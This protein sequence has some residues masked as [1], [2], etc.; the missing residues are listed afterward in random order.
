MAIL[1]KPVLTFSATLA[2]IGLVRRYGAIATK[3]GKQV[4]TSSLSDKIEKREKIGVNAA[5]FLE[6]IRLLRICVPSILS[7]E[8]GIA[9]LIAALMVGR[10]ECSRLK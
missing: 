3:A 7:P 8:A 9:L 1:S 2:L 5:F 4:G 6:L 10:S